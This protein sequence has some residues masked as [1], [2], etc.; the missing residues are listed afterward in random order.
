MTDQIKEILLAIGS[1]MGTL[2]LIFTM[3]ITWKRY[4]IQK[5]MDRIN[6]DT[7]AMELA[8]KYEKRVKEIEDKY[9]TAINKI[10]LLNRQIEN[11]QKRKVNVNIE[12][13]FD[14]APSV[15]EYLWK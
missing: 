6:K 3:F 13:E 11:M 9:E 12:F 2:S 10:E 14:Q 7:F 4:P 5:T 15:L 1:V 8:E